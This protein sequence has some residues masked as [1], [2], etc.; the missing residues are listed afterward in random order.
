MAPFE[1]EVV[2]AL[3]DPGRRL[4][5]R[6]FEQLVAST[7]SGEGSGSA[8]A[9]FEYE[10]TVRLPGMSLKEIY[11]ALEDAPAYAAL[12]ERLGLSPRDCEHL[13]Q[14]EISRKHRAKALEWVE[15]G[16]ALKAARNWHNEA[17]YGLEHLALP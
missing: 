10:N 15:K 8:K 14:M 3:D 13:A 4:F 5:I 9:I 6:H 12:C 2:K 7:I 1:G 11:E 17:A 16:T